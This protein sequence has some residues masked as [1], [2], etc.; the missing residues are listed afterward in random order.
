MVRKH[1]PGRSPQSCP[2]G[3]FIPFSAEKVQND[4]AKALS[5]KISPGGALRAVSPLSTQIGV[6]CEST[7]L[8]D[9]PRGALRAVSEVSTQ[10]WAFLKNLPFEESSSQSTTVYAKHSSIFLL[11]PS[12]KCTHFLLRRKFRASRWVSRNF[13]FVTKKICSSRRPSIP[14][15]RHL[16]L[17]FERN[18]DQERRYLQDRR[19]NRWNLESSEKRE[20]SESLCP[21]R[22][23]F[24]ATLESKIWILRNL[25]HICS[26]CSE[27]HWVFNVALILQVFFFVP[28]CLTSLEAIF[29]RNLFVFFL[30]LRQQFKCERVLRVLPEGSS[31]SFSS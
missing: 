11:S 6:W 15:F 17:N 21:F 24:V 13:F 4:G 16:E 3:D 22:T 26:V 19:R 29:R 25:I 30:F 18:R 5:S 2:S 12:W 20:C 8:R 14:G 27:R 31:G 9:S 28:C 7:L 23:T 10:I 1:S